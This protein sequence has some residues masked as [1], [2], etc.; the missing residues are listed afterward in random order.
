MVSFVAFHS[1]L[2]LVLYLLNN[3]H[4]YNKMATSRARAMRFSNDLEILK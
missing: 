4:M 3:V 2:Q 1:V